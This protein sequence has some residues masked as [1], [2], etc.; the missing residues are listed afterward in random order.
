MFFTRS[1]LLSSAASF[2]LSSTGRIGE[3]TEISFGFLLILAATPTF[4]SRTGGLRQRAG[5]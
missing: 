1:H 3:T 4:P 5:E 2:A